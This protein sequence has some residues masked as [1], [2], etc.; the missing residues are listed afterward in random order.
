MKNLKRFWAILL[1]VIMVVGV[2]PT[3]VF[4]LSLLRGTE[5]T[6]KE[7]I[8]G[9]AII[10]RR[11]GLNEVLNNKETDPLDLER[12]EKEPTNSRTMVFDIVDGG[13]SCG[14]SKTEKYTLDSSAFSFYDLERDGRPSDKYDNLTE[15]EKTNLDTLFTLAPL[16]LFGS[17]VDGGFAQLENLKYRAGDKIAYC[18]DLGKAAPEKTEMSYSPENDP[19]KNEVLNVLR[20]G[21]PNKTITGK[22]MLF[23]YAT[24]IAVKMADGRAFNTDGRE[25]DGIDVTMLKEAP[26]AGAKKEIIPTYSLDGYKKLFAKLKDEDREFLVERA[27]FASDLVRDLMEKANGFESKREE[28]FTGP[29][30]V[31]DHKLFGPFKF[32]L[33]NEDGTTPAK[34]TLRPR[35]ASGISAEN[36]NVF[37]ADSKGSPINPENNKEFYIGIKKLEEGK[38]PITLTAVAN[39]E[40]TLTNVF[41][42]ADKDNPSLDGGGYQRMYVAECAP[43]MAVHKLIVEK[44]NKPEPKLTTVTLTK[45]DLVSGDPVEGAVIEVR[46][47]NGELVGGTP[48]TTPKD[49]KVE[50]KDLAPGKYTFKETIAPKGYILNEE[51]CEFTIDENGNV[52]GKTTLTNEKDTKSTTVTITKTDLVDGTPVVGATIEVRNEKGEL[53]GGTPV[54]TPA[55]GKVEIKDLVPGKYTF[56]ETIA[57]NG[58][59][60]N[61]EESTF[62]IDKDGKV[63]GKTTLTNKREDGTVVLSKTDLVDG[64]GVPGA[65]IEVID[66]DGKQIAGSPFI[67]DENGNIVIKDLKPGTYT[68]KETVA[69]K[70]YI[71]SEEVCEFTLGADGKVTGKTTL[72]NERNEFIISKVDAKTKNPMPNVVF[73]ITDANGK[74]VE[75][76]P[77]TTDINGRI[78]LSG[79]EFGKYKISEINTPKGY[80]KMA[81]VEFEI[82]KET[83]KKGLVLENIPVDIKLTKTDSKTNLPVPGAE[84]EIKKGDAVVATLKTDSKGEIDLSFL[85]AGTYTIRETK[86]PAG[87]LLDTTQKTVVINENCE[88]TGDMHFVNV[89]VGGKIT[90]VDALNGEPLEGAIFTFFDQDGNKVIDFQ[91]DK[92]GQINPSGLSVGNYTFKETTAPKGYK[93]SDETYRVSIMPDGSIIGD[94]IIKNEPNIVTLKKV[95]KEKT[96]LAG[97]EFELKDENGNVVKTIVSDKIGNM[98]IRGLAVGNYSL[99]ETKAPKGYIKSDKVYR[100]SVTAD[101]QVTGDTEIMNEDTFVEIVKE[102]EK[103]DKL[104]GA[105][106]ELSEYNGKFLAKA[107]T[108][109]DGKITVRRLPAGKY[110]LKETKAPNGYVLSDKEYVIEMSEDGKVTG[111]TTIVNKQ[112]EIV[113]KKLDKDTKDPLDGAKFTLKSGSKIIDKNIESDRRGEIILKGLTEGNYTLE[114]TEA[115]DGYV[116]ASKE[117]KF[118]IDKN[119]KLKGEDTIYNSKASFTLVKKDLTTGAVLEGASFVIRDKNDKIVAKVT[120]NR[121]GE[122][123]VDGLGQGRYSIEETVAPEGYVKATKAA[124]FEVDKDGKIKGKDVL[125]IFNKA[126]GKKVEKPNEPTK[127]TS[128]NKPN[129]LK[130]VKPT[131]NYTPAPSTP[132]AVPSAPGTTTVTTPGEKVKTGDKTKNY[133]V[134]ALCGAGLIGL[135][136]FDKKK[137]NKDDK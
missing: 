105:E 54:V 81:T 123:V 90:K 50:I 75:G 124:T 1:A 47:E 128:T 120:T 5:N 32:N 51:T 68:F 55:D 30:L 95:N 104:E 52:T 91:T 67:T 122:A 82:N 69:P 86:A 20:A 31:N 111:D 93:S 46:D 100:I 125:E 26:T 115:P 109:K 78:Q 28:T 107:K 130:E 133:A 2:L 79:F 112:A 7:K 73:R 110:I 85:E 103:G 88:V 25:I 63:T 137:K 8:E 121:N 64:K 12:V 65:K 40:N 70:G 136:L 39:G 48:V 106:F 131:E 101:G 53:V 19:V 33:V 84:F 66:K 6:S 80:K 134:I 3:D 135:F 34:I 74:V 98:E 102:N 96:G 15:A 97:A 27:A 119:G 71:L 10:E 58:Y 61:T 126:E 14:T 29:K 35:L 13:I 83:I 43:L 38:Y 76:S 56:K 117:F 9:S 37:F 129:E 114:E 94:T 60:L 44:T 21:Y 11:D 116:K 132:S 45:T 22:E 72:T 89:Q 4:A 42:H 36:G 108:D 23:E 57:P 41:Y 99:T 62:T 118:T 17:E 87:Y 77:F 59:V 16:A 113:L 92:N 24:A 18:L 127:P 49:G